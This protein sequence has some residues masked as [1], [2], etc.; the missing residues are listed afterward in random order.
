MTSPNAFA[1]V[2][3]AGFGRRMQQS[4]SVTAPKQYLTIRGKTIL[5]WTLETLD[6][7]PGLAGIVVVIGPEDN[8]FEELPLDLDKPLTIVEGGA[9]RMHSVLNGLRA[10]EDHARDDDWVLV[11][12]AVRPC[13]SLDD[14]AQLFREVTNDPAL[15]GGLLAVPVRETLKRVKEGNMVDCTV[16]REEYWC[17]ATPQMFRYQG[18]FHALK[19][20]VADN[21]LITDEAHAMEKVGYQVKLVEG[22]ADN[23][24][25]TRIEDL[26]L[27]EHI[28]HSQEML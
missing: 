7:I 5:Q 28:L 21:M 24:K 10:L 27:A 8:W 11:H 23:I 25:I 9:E 22:R 1:I 6:R 16:P 19:Q 18:L 12:D 3:A 4:G 13:A 2:P 14:I 17:A 15:A 20:A 26:A